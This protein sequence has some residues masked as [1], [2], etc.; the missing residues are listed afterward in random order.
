MKCDVTE[1]QHIEQAFMHVKT[2][3]KK[4]DVIINNAG[5]MNDALHM[6]QN[7]CKVNI[8]SLKIQ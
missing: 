7:A 5:I 3:Y 6:W 4:V 2:V 1:E 8:V